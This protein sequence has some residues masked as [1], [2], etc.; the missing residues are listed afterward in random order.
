M[1]DDKTAL[2][3]WNGVKTEDGEILRYCPQIYPPRKLDYIGFI[4]YTKMFCPRVEH[5]RKKKEL[6]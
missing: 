1:R 3:L 4:D 5:K 2:R 6:R